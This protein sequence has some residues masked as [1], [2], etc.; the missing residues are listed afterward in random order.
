MIEW[1]SYAMEE[2]FL[3]A[4][5]GRTPRLLL[6]LSYLPFSR[7]WVWFCLFDLVKRYTEHQHNRS[8]K[9][10]LCPSFILFNLTLHHQIAQ[11][12][13]GI[14]HTSVTKVTE[15]DG[16]LFTI[17][18]ARI[19]AHRNHS[20][21]LLLAPM[22]DKRRQGFPIIETKSTTINLRPHGRTHL[23]SSKTQLK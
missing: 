7:S 23:L 12:N 17:V 19:L 16:G 10:G 20:P 1:L 22:K 6:W 15:S 8:W 5:R 21:V 14:R 11:K 18:P 4:W 3:W 13:L 9:V 2:V